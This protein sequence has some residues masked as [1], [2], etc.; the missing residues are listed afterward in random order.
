MWG[1]FYPLYCSSGTWRSSSTWICPWMTSPACRTAWLD[2]RHSSGLIWVETDCST[3]LKT[4]TG[5][6]R[7]ETSSEPHPPQ[8]SATEPQKCVLRMEKLHTLW[9]QRN[10]LEKLPENIS[11]MA[12]LDTLVLSSNRLRDIPP[13]MEDMCN[14]RWDRSTLRSVC[15]STNRNII[16][17]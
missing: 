1:L 3:Y 2:C 7:T 12:S 9:L 10:E 6:W 13:L 15:L 17:C 14:L 4:Y 5:G 16:D 8:L 11:R